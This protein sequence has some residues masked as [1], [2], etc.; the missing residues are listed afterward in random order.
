[1]LFEVLEGAGLQVDTLDAW[2]S[3]MPP[4]RRDD[5]PVRLGDNW[6][7]LYIAYPAS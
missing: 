7:W 1:M 3:G 4:V 5:F 6:H 2:L